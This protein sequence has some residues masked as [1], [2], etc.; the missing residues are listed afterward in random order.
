MKMLPPFRMPGLLPVVLP[1]HL[2]FATSWLIGMVFLLTWGVRYADKHRLRTWGIRLIIAGIL[3]SVIT[4]PLM[5]H[6]QIPDGQ[7]GAPYMMNR[8]VMRQN[9]ADGRP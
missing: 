3:G 9:P 7:N 8:G 5:A 4:I 2:A 1:I 6:R